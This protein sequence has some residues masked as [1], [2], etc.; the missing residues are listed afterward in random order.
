MK[1]LTYRKLTTNHA[2]DKPFILR[3]FRGHSRMNLQLF[4]DGE[5][6]DG[7]G[8]GENDGDDSGKDAAGGSGGDGDD[9]GGKDGGDKPRTYS[10]ADVDRIIAK[11]KAEWEKNHASD[12]EKAKEEARKY[13]RMTKEQ[14]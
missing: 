9:K 14:K 4:A 12:L 2:K 8:G 3:D 11:K 5:D 6:G 7:S 10:D 13:E 1:N